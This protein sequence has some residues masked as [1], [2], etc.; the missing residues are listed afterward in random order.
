MYVDR[1]QLVG[2]RHATA[3]VFVL[4]GLPPRLW[5]LLVK[6]P[7]FHRLMIPGGHVEPGEQPW[8]TASRE[9]REETGVSV[10]VLSCGLSSEVGPLCDVDLAPV[11]LWIAIEHIPAAADMP[12]HQHV[13]H[14]FLA[15]P[16]A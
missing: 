16:E 15:V 6:H 3:S 14:L 1:S 2:E 12:A 10:K 7:K 11:P 9:V 8:E 4:D 13:D 5:L